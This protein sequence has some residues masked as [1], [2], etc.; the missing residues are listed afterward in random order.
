MNPCLERRGPHANRA[1]LRVFPCLRG[2]GSRHA[3]YRGVNGISSL[4]GTLSPSLPARGKSM[5]DV[6]A[7]SPDGGAR[8]TES[9]ASAMALSFAAAFGMLL[10]GTPARLSSQ[11]PLSSRAPL[12]SPASASRASSERDSGSISSAGLSKNRPERIEAGS[13]ART[14]SN[15]SAHASSGMRSRE[16]Q[17]SRE[18]SGGAA[19]AAAPRGSASEASAAHG[20]IRTR[21]SVPGTGSGN[22]A[23]PDT[24]TV[25]SNAR[26]REPLDTAQ[27]TEA[28]RGF[29]TIRGSR[30]AD[31]HGERIQH[32]TGE[33]P[34][35]IPDMEQGDAL[36]SFPKGPDG[37]S[38][39]AGPGGHAPAP[40]MN[41]DTLGFEGQAQDSYSYVKGFA[42]PVIASADETTV[43]ETGLREGTPGTGQAAPKTGGGEV[44]PHLMQ[45]A[46]AVTLSQ[47]VTD[48]STLSSDSRTQGPADPA[49]R[50]GAVP[51]GD[52]RSSLDSSVSSVRPSTLGMTATAL[53]ET[54]DDASVS[55]PEGSARFGV[56]LALR[57]QQA[58]NPTAGF[59]NGNPG[60]PGNPALAEPGSGYA[61]SA[62]HAVPGDGDTGVGS[63]SP[64]RNADVATV[65][66]KTP[67]VDGE[68]SAA[69]APASAAAP[70]IRGQQI[71][72]RGA[73]RAIPGQVSAMAAAALARAGQSQGRQAGTGDNRRESGETPQGFRPFLQ[74]TAGDA[75]AASQESGR[76]VGADASIAGGPRRASLQ[77]A[78]GPQAG[79][80][81]GSGAAALAPSLSAAPGGGDALRASTQG[82]RQASVPEPEAATAPEALAALRN[83]MQPAAARSMLV[84]VPGELHGEPLQLRF[85]QRGEQL[86]VRLASGSEVAA[87]EIREHLPQL[88]ARLGQIGFSAERVTD[89][90]ASRAQAGESGF[91][92]QGQRGDESSSRHPSGG[93]SPGRE[94]DEPHGMPGN[95]MASR[96]Q[97]GASSFAGYLR[98]A[99][100]GTGTTQDG[101]HTE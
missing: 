86:D 58:A 29:N 1:F 19:A 37:I 59:Q 61:A 23:M 99:D 75:D 13:R 4:G 72:E 97:H 50:T 47:T 24:T 76:I 27:A 10:Q 85:L 51:D 69:P 18:Q 68:A 71:G 52:P 15:P 40:R 9:N 55:R 82:A 35:A 49:A 43:P 32:L 7:G 2:F 62:G 31:G 60:I 38:P 90:E 6:P 73:M 56:Q 100:A 57:A 28:E 44:T 25:R 33:T 74:G 78:A 98:G 84:R 93:D 53:I 17:R 91:R 95:Q 65:A 96:R 101:R 12:G 30:K 67:S 79:V 81:S 89:L 5:A 54:T 46:P 3:G 16:V 94:S 88:L 14:G 64:Q 45:A 20:S 21:S 92:G 42:P 8:D 66:M 63:A 87:R 22:R 48:G 83:I 39:E 11:A 36:P 70:Q 80:H 41:P 26:N 34:G 77:T